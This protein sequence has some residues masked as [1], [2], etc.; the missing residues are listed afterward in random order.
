MRAMSGQKKRPRPGSFAESLSTLGQLY[1]RELRIKPL[2]ADEER[3]DA[4]YTTN[5]FTGTSA[6]GERAVVRKATA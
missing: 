4:F 6:R 5:H 1:A 3:P 2:A